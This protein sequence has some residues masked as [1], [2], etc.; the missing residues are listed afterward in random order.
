M[1]PSMTKINDRDFAILDHVDRH[2]LASREI[3]HQ[4]FFPNASR[5]AVGK[6]I[7]RLTQ[8]DWLREHRLA[9]GFSYCTLGRRGV[10]HLA[11]P[12]QVVRPIHRADPPGR[13][14]IFRILRRPI[15]QS[16]HA[17]EFQQEFPALCPPQTVTSGYFRYT[18]A[19]QTHLAVAL[20]DRANTQR[21]LFR[22]AGPIDPA[23]LP[24]SRILCPD[25]PAA[26]LH[27]NSYG[28]ARQTGIFGCCFAQE[29]L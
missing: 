17:A 14:R 10:R 12:A 2:R 21:H 5:N 22:K 27:Y 29:I 25:S 6:V 16:P 3:L 20:V 26:V 19:G 8:H 23:A 9:N 13:L 7:V 1:N 11:A 15:H 18:I 28:L 24:D 4:L